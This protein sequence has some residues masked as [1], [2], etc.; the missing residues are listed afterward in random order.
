MPQRRRCAIVNRRREICP[1]FE[2]VLPPAPRATSTWEMP[3]RRFSTGCLR[4]I[5]AAPLSCAL[6]TRT[7]SAPRQEYERQ[8]I[9]DLRWFGLDWDEGPDKGGAVW[10]LPPVGAQ[11]DL[12]PAY[13]ELIEQ[14]HAYFCF[15][16]AEQ[17]EPERQEELKAGRQPRYSGRCR[18]LPRE[19]AAR[20]VAAGEPAAMRLKIMESSFFL[21]RPRARAHH[22]FGGGHRRSRPGALRRAFPLTIMRW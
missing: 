1:R 9:E 17:L 15:C 18:K 6:K 13:P 20:K 11:G 5:T 16:T 8:L 10:P 4:G 21:E 3:G 14:G 2:F 7:P 19:E 12:C 22:F